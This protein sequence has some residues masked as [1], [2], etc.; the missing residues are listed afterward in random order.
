MDNS[1]QRQIMYNLDKTSRKI[2]HSMRG[3]YI[4]SSLS[5][6]Y[7]LQFTCVFIILPLITVGAVWW[8][9]FCILVMSCAFSHILVIYW[10]NCGRPYSKLL[11]RS[12][13]GA[14]TIIRYI[15]TWKQEIPNL[16]NGPGET[17]TRT[18]NPLLRKSTAKLLHHCCSPNFLIILN[19]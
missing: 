16:W 12:R 5:K 10:R 8:L 18:L 13:E 15:A 6:V 2:Q 11:T 7:N 19:K 14:L 3:N 17:R 4:H 9:C 1:H